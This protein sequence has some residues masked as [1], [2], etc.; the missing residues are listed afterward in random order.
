SSRPLNS[1]CQEKSTLSS[2]ARERER[3][4]FRNTFVK[5]RNTMSFPKSL[6]SRIFRSTNYIPCQTTNIQCQISILR[7][8]KYIMY[9]FVCRLM[10]SNEG[11]DP[12]IGKLLSEMY[13]PD[14]KTNLQRMIER[15][16]TS[17][18]SISA[19]GSGA[20]M[21]RRRESE[22]VPWVDKCDILE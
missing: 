11:V 10:S 12:S 1:F 15:W 13:A 19:F 2:V 16:T 7:L 4:Q 8:W 9:S 20:K 6:L 18:F 5:Y 22:E 3:P 14:A 17:E 21:A